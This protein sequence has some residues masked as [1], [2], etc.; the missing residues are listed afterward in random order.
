MWGPNC[1]Q[2]VAAFFGVLRAR[3]ALV[4]LDP[5]ATPEFLG[6]VLGHTGAELLI[7]GLDGQTPTRTLD[8]F[9]LPFD[10]G[11]PFAGNH[12]VPDDI[13]EIVFTSGTTASPKG[14]V[15]THANVVANV[16]SAEA[17]LEPTRDFRLLSVLP[18]SH[19]FEQTAGLFLPLFVGASVHY[20]TSRQ[21]PVLLKTLRRHRV[22]AMSVVPKSSSSC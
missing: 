16:R 22:T 13:A 2:L 9:A 17:A 7:S 6:R 18:L 12:P 20:A 5:Y 10:T 15:L 1:P 21:S 11:R 3:L 8:L 14:V 19:M 4:P